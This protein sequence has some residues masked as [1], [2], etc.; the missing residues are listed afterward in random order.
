MSLIE[1]MIQALRK[2]HYLTVPKFPPPGVVKTHLAVSLALKA[3]QAGI[4]IYNFRD[5]FTFLALIKRIKILQAIFYN[6]LTITFIFR[7]Y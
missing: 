6:C 4:T 2:K 3:C 7:D 1:K 5:S